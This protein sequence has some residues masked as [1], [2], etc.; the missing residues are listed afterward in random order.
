MKNGVVFIA[1]AYGVGKSTLCSKL[2]ATL[3]I[4]SFSAG[5]LISDVNGEIYGQ[6]KVVKDKTENQN[7]LIA[8]VKNRLNTHPTFLLAGH[9]CIFNKNDEVEVLPEFVYKE[10]PISKILLLE[11]DGD[12]IIRNIKS[13]D[14]KSYSITSIENLIET[15]RNQA[16]KFSHQLDIPLCIHK[17]KFDQTDV[18]IISTL[19]KGS[20]T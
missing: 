6:N 4:P 11:S 1:G 7:I 14:N 18:D 10:L 8:A 16:V 9:F 2:S 17:M 20:D 5:D 12:T 3:G 13:R 19:L 15:E